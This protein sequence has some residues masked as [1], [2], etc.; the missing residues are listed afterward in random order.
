MV[1]LSQLD[2]GP[3]S[4]RVVL[5]GSRRVLYN[6]TQRAIEVPSAVP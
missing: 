6:E 5:I 2:S 4:L 1:P 3:H